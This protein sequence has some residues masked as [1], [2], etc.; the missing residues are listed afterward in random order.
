[1]D[2]ARSTLHLIQ[3]ASEL[4]DHEIIDKLLA[5][6]R[7]VETMLQPDE[8]S[9]VMVQERLRTI[10]I[11]IDA[12]QDGQEWPSAE[13][14]LDSG[15]DKA[16]KIVQRFGDEKAVAALNGFEQHADAI[17]REKN[18]AMALELL[19][20]ISSFEFELMSQ[21]IGFWV[22]IIK[23]VNDDFE[24][25]QWKDRQLAKKILGSAKAIISVQPSKEKLRD[26]VL[27]LFSL[28]PEGDRPI[29]D[30]PD[31]SLLKT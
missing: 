4:V 30:T 1:V 8:D 6:L 19:E 23:E 14:Q 27:H 24:A 31:G 25:Y 3:N 16:R 22:A 9:R 10:F 7:E 18:T 26:C 21:D 5:D 17:R 2:K 28:M 29:L 15:L 13:E 20:Q 11:S 12:I